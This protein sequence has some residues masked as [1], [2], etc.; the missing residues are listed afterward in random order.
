M[1]KKVL[2]GIVLLVIL[3][4]LIAFTLP[5]K[6]AITDSTLVQAPSAFTYDEINELKNWSK[7]SYWEMHDTT[8]KITYGEI[9][10]GI[11]ASYSWTSS[12]GPGSLLVTE[13]IPNKL[14]RFDMNF[15]EGGNSAYGWY[16]FEE[17]GN[18]TRIT[19]GFEFDHGFNPL[20]RW[21]GKLFLEQEIRKSMEYQLAKLKELAEAK[22]I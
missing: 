12:E 8:I 13:C 14:V 19:S 11:N 21:I 15:M 17:E 5:S 16:T 1:L 20:S 9:T 22:P 7:W 18:A 3:L 6:I 2:I 10:S 4:L